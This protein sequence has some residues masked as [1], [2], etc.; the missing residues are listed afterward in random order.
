MGQSRFALS[1]D[2]RG[3]APWWIAH[4]ESTKHRCVSAAH[5][6]PVLVYMDSCGECRLGA[7]VIIDGV[8]TTRQSHVPDWFGRAKTGIFELE[9]LGC[10]LGLIIACQ[11]VP[12][13]PVLLRFDNLGDRGAV[14]RGRV[15]PP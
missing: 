11:A 3:V 9:L 2:M 13:R 5:Q 10:I 12:R 15:P 1:G 4:L 14:V 7:V 6:R 8:R